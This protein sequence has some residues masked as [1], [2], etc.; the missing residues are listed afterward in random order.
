MFTARRGETAEQF[1]SIS[2][3]SS[4]GSKIESTELFQCLFF[5]FFLAIRYCN[6][7]SY[8]QCTCTNPFC[9]SFQKRYIIIIVFVQV[10]F[11]GK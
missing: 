6:R 7:R 1:P 9:K 8:C 2:E 5:H 11:G 4:V 10:V 3:K